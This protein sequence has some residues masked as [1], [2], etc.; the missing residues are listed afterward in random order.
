MNQPTLSRLSIKLIALCVL[1]TCLILFTN[2]ATYSRLAPPAPQIL[3]VQI[4]PQPQSPLQISSTKILSSDPFS[5]NIEFTV[6]NKGGKGI[7]AYTVTR[8]LETDGGSR[9]AAIFTQLTNQREILQPGQ[10]RSGGIKE[11][12]SPVFVNGVVL[13][14]DFVEFDDGGTWGKDTYNSAER[15]AGQ[16][17][18]GR[19]AL[20]HLRKVREEK[21]ATALL[22][23]IESEGGE[24][25][26]SEGHSAEW[27]DGFKSGVALA[28]FR[29][30]KASQENGVKGVEEELQKPFDAAEGRPE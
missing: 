12:Y 20:E 22:E 29:L 5:P 1:V 10:S 9:K 2:K 14:I 6:T 21:G 13:S 15:L 4:Q 11:S 19:N 7:R 8:E 16:R 17:A 27:Q 30:K 26:T 25:A 23:A 24:I 28:H 18:G 3:T